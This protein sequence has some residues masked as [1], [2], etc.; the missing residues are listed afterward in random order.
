[1]GRAVSPLNAHAA[2]PVGGALFSSWWGLAARAL[3]FPWFERMVG[4][5]SPPAPVADDDAFQRLRARAS[6]G[7]PGC[8]AAQRELRAATLRGL[9]RCTGKPVPTVRP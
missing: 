2:S 3:K 5:P 8:A 1:M 6:S 9:A 7:V 4:D